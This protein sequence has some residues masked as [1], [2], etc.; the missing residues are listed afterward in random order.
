M[1][2]HESVKHTIFE[3]PAEIRTKLLSLMNRL[4]L[5]F[6]CVDMIL[7]PRGEYV[8]LEVNPAGQWGWI[9]QMTGMPITEA[10]VDLLVSEES[11][12]SSSQ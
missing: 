1:A 6:G 3:L 4:S 9:E 7:T 12:V 10:L 2:N 11:V 5:V 8:F